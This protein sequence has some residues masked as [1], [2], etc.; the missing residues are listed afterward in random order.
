MDPTIPVTTLGKIDEMNHGTN[1][2][3]EGKFFY[4]LIKAPDNL[5]FVY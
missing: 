5:L 1:M 2:G 4:I 3:P